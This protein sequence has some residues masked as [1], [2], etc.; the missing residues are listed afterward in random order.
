M[1]TGETNFTGQCGATNGPFATMDITGWE[2]S[3][4]ELLED[5]VLDVYRPPAN[6]TYTDGNPA[7]NGLGCSAHWFNWSADLGSEGDYMVALGSFEH[8]ARF[9]NV[10]SADGKITEVGWFQPFN[11]S[12][13]GAYWLDEQHVYVVDY[14]RGIDIL[15]VNFDLE[16]R[17]DDQAVAMSWLAS[18]QRPQLDITRAE[19][20]SCS[21]A[22]R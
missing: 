18:A 21:L 9:L 5:R 3:G 4:A 17:P 19:Q 10:D 22:M 14:V 13:S 7:V 16:L 6:G 8:G 12:A 15:R 2:E 20:L 11:G 1:I